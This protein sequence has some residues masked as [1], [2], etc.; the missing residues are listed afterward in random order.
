MQTLQHL[1]APTFHV[2]ATPRPPEVA[3]RVK[4]L[5]TSKVIKVLNTTMDGM[6]HLLAG[7]TPLPPHAAEALAKKLQLQNYALHGAGVARLSRLSA[8]LA[9]NPEVV[10]SKLAPADA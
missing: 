7:S 10:N 2:A 1:P 9:E 8:V 3:K 6:E 4:N 5:L